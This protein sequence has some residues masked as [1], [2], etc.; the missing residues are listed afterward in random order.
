MNVTALADTVDL[1]TIGSS[2]ATAAENAIG[3]GVTAVVPV[4]AL[5]IGVR[6]VIGLVKKNSNA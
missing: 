6:I 4:I 5:I 1:S 3:T 2:L